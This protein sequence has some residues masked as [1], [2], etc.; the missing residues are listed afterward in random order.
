M[1]QTSHKKTPFWEKMTS[2]G[3]NGHSEKDPSL[4]TKNA[5]SDTNSAK[6]N[7]LMRQTETTIKA[8]LKHT[9]KAR[10]T[11][12]GLVGPK[13]RLVSSKSAP[14]LPGPEAVPI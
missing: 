7:L 12:S 1:N 8:N 9:K 11:P 5:E 4:K 14:P 10:E 3:G 13:R 6:N 2:S